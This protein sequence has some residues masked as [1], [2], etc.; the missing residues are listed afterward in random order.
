MKDN[1]FDKI[2]RSKAAEHEAKV[3]MSAWEN[4]V[5]KK[6]KRRYFFWWLGAII[7]FLSGIGWGI[8]HSTQ[9]TIKPQKEII[10]LENAINQQNIQKSSPL[11]NESL[12][13]IDTNAAL[14]NSSESTKANKHVADYVVNPIEGDDISIIE[15]NASRSKLKKLRSRSNNITVAR[16]SNTTSSRTTNGRSL[17]NISNATVA[18]ETNQFDVVD[19]E[20]YVDA[21]KNIKL[22]SIQEFP[23]ISSVNLLSMRRQIFQR[24][25]NPTDS[26]KNIMKAKN[27]PLKVV[28][29]WNVEFAVG[30]FIPI[31]IEDKIMELNR[32]TNLPNGNAFFKTDNISISNRTGISY[33]IL[34]NKKISKKWSA[35]IGLEYAL[36]KETLHL[37]GKETQEI[38]SIVDRLTYQNG[39]PVLVKDSVLN[40]ITGNRIIDATN[41]YQLWNVPIKF[42]YDLLMNRKYNITIIGGANLNISQQYKNSITGS[43]NNP[44]YPNPPANERK[45]LLDLFA[46]IKLN[47]K[48]NS[49][50]SFFVEPSFQYNFTKYSMNEQLNHTKLHRAAIKLGT[51]IQLKTK[52]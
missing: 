14:P 29:G 42:G 21:E 32:I 28:S 37:N 49:H 30:N 10:A 17:I 33:S 9:N 39:N 7:L 16:L 11:K 40:K 6:R 27:I 24:Q 19:S 12:T 35:G 23:L 48:I 26:Q 18:Q 15:N 4:I 34:V 36:I 5:Q 50:F 1:L 43:F 38:Y 51:N 20:D 3:P 47:K 8:L 13:K 25:I 22:R 46:G 41:S 44:I 52:K 31:R 45:M 2:I